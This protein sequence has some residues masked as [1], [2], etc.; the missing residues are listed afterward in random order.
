MKL[1]RIFTVGL[2]ALMLLPSLTM[3]ACKKE[4]KKPEKQKVQNVYRSEELLK[5]KFSYDDSMEESYRYEGLYGMGEDIILSATKWT[6]D[7]TTSNVYFSVDTETGVKTELILPALQNEG[8]YR[9]SMI[10]AEDGTAWYGEEHYTFDEELGMEFANLC[11]IHADTKGNL[12]AKAD[13]YE[14]VGAD[15]TMEYLY[16]NK[17]CVWQGELYLGL[18]TGLYRINTDL[19]QATAIS[20]D[21]LGFVSNLIPMGEELLISY[22]TANWTTQAVTYS[23]ATNTVSAPLAL[24]QAVL[25][26]ITSGIQSATYDFVFFDTLA[27]YGYDLET[28]TKTELLNWINSDMDATFAN[29]TH[30][31]PS[32]TVYSLMNDWSDNVTTQTLYK[33]TRI[34][35]E[36]VMEKYIIT[37]GALYLDYDVRKS[38]IAFNRQSEEYRITIRDYSEYNTEE[39]DYMGALPQFNND[40]VAGKAPDLIQISSEMP[41]A[42]YVAKGL[43]TDLYPF[44]DADESFAREDFYQNIL[45]AFSVNGKLYELAPTFALQTLVGKSELVG[46]SDGWTMD[47]MLAAVK[48]FGNAEMIFGGEMTRDVFLESVCMLTYEQF[49]DKNTGRCNFNSEEFI[50]ILEFCKT[51]PEKTIWD[52]MDYETMDPNFWENQEYLYRRDEALLLNFYFSNYRDAWTTQEGRFG[53]HISFVGYPN[54]ARNGTSMYPIAEFAISAKSACKDGAWAFISYMLTELEKT[55]AEE[56]YNFSVLRSVNE[57]M[58]QS[59]LEYY[60]PY[61]DEN[62]GGLVIMPGSS[63]VETFDIE[64]TDD[65]TAPTVDDG[66]KHWGY[67]IG[68]EQIDIGQMNQELVDHV[69]SIIEN[70]SHVNRADLDM[71]DIIKE[72]VSA[73]F[74]GQKDAK[75]VAGLIQSRVTTYIN[76][77]R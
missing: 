38:V 12:L 64:E 70:V 75:T 67:Y 34:P 32:G 27:V 69:N 62:S 74:A 41:F 46:A 56:L 13:L 14:L 31:A 36:E 48:K 61:W 30:I 33:L 76:T 55:D 43:F 44:I 71:I 72:D 42:S 66:E 54:E 28:G 73:F 63:F 22:S 77:N 17:M 47:E 59:A 26:Y 8:A 6:E 2:A 4:E 16:I 52:D 37:F 25:N 20:L 60:D 7:F 9:S 10:F 24:E 15:P 19:T 57:K 21:N 23:P 51:L 65:E 40:I 29:E 5:N 11:L 50:K 1:K 39:N 68:A 18:E 3:T 35:D 49:V 45:D 58:A 53:A